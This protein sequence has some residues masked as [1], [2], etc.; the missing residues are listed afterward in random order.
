MTLRNY[1]AAHKISAKLFLKKS[2]R[3]VS[4]CKAMAKLA[5]SL[6]TGFSPVWYRRREPAVLTASG[7]QNAASPF[8]V[9]FQPSLFM[10]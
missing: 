1:P 4:K 6:A 3:V 9:I 10:P 2:W 7:A 5:F 8:F